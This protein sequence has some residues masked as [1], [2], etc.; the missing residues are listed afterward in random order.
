MY[1]G[2][3]KDN[4]AKNVPVANA[5]GLLFHEVQNATNYGRQF[6]VNDTN[7]FTRSLVKGT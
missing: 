2:Y 3:I 5:K 1:V 7:I 4:G 6:F